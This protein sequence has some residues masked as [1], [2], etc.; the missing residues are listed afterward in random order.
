LCH[1][2]RTINAYPPL[3]AL[4]VCE[5]TR[6]SSKSVF[7]T[8]ILSRLNTSNPFFQLCSSAK[9]SEEVK[10]NLIKKK[11]REFK[12][13]MGDGRWSFKG[14]G[15]MMPTFRFCLRGASEDFVGVGALMETSK[16]VVGG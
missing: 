15:I 6:A 10:K 4:R 11:K 12:N 2:C 3:G 13:M 1:I 14:F 7:F 9:P 5:T 16:S 8:W